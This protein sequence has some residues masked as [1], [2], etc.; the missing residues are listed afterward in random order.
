MVSYFSNSIRRV[1]ISGDKFAW[2]THSFSFSRT[3]T[4]ASFTL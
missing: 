3:H 1:A 2:V 4:V